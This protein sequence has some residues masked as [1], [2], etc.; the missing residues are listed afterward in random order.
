VRGADGNGRSQSRGRRLPQVVLAREPEAKYHDYRGLELRM[1]RIIKEPECC[2]HCQ[3][4]FEIVCVKFGFGGAVTVSAC[5]NCAIASADER[6]AGRFAKI[7]QAFW[8]AL[9]MMEALNSRFRFMV[10]TLT[11]AAVIAG[12]LRHTAHVY[13]GFSRE[14]IRTSAL[15]VC[16]VVSLLLVIVENKRRR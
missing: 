2:P 8:A 15:L 7:A 9:S 1:S 13:G 10:A 6:S 5:P 11:A 4:R 12:L 14:E 16:L 3:A